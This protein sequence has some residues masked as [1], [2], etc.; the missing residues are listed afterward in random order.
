MAQDLSSVPLGRNASINRN[1]GAAFGTVTWLAI[2]NIQDVTLTSAR[3]KGDVSVR[4]S[5]FKQ[6]VMGQRD[7]AVT[8]SLVLVKAD[9]GYQALRDAHI[10]GT[11]IQ[12]AV[13]DE[14]ATVSGAY[15]LNADW[16]V[17]E[18]SPGQPLDDGI[19]FD[20][21]LCMAKTVNAPAAITIAGA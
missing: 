7:V 19:K 12:L 2:P 14:A 17:D 20:V 16:H 18:F 6:Y 5:E 13:L 15:G 10:A 21:K 1:T 11:P 4:G 8:F 3:A 9:S